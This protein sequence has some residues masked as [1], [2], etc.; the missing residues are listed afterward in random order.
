MQPV[1]VPGRCD[2]LLVGIADLDGYTVVA[3][4]C[5]ASSI[6][7]LVQIDSYAYQCCCCIVLPTMLLTSMLL[8]E[9]IL[10]SNLGLLV[11][12]AVDV[13]L[14]V[15]AFVAVPAAATAHMQF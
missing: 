15:S 3:M 11:A 10:L 13:V 6:L 4:L 1:H 7:W 2:A 5:G 14:H 9:L 8:Y 12:S